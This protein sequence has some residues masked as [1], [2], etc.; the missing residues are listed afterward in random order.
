M[1]LQNELVQQEK[2]LND[3]KVNQTQQY[4]TTWT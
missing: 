4:K 1:F 3:S 2:S